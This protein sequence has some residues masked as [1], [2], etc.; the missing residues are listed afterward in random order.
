MKKLF[1]ILLVMVL[2]FST[3]VAPSCKEKDK[4]ETTSL[5][6]EPVSFEKTDVTLVNNKKSDY[7]IVIPDS[8]T[9]METHAA[10]ELQLFIKEST[11]CTL[12]IISD[13]GLTHDNSKKYLSVGETSLLKE[14]TDIEIKF[15]VMGEAGPTVMRRDNTV[16]MC[17]AHAYGTLNSVYKFL[18]Y[19]IGFMAYSIDCVKYDYFTDLKL[20]DFNY[21]YVPTVGKTNSHEDFGED[22]LVALGRM[23]MNTNVPNLGTVELFE[24]M[25]WDGYFCHTNQFIVPQSEYPHLYKNN[26]IC[27]TSEEALQVFCERLFSLLDRNKQIDR[28]NLGVNDFPTSCDC[29][30]CKAQTAKYNGGGVLIR[31]C[32][33]VAKYVENKFIEQGS[34][35]KVELVPLIYYNYITPP[36]KEGA[37]GTLVPI[38]DTVIP[39]SDGQVTIG[40][41]YT[42]ILSCYQHSYANPCDTNIT[43]RDDILGWKV[44][45]DTFYMYSY[46]ANFPG[47]HTYFDNMEYLDEQFKWYH[48]NGIRFT[49]LYE[50]GYGADLGVLDPL[51]MYVRARLGWNPLLNLDELIKDFCENYYGDGGEWVEKYYRATQEH[52][53][54]IYNEKA[55]DCLLPLTSSTANIY[56]PRQTLSAFEGILLNGMSAINNSEY[57]DKDKAL[58]SE[59][60]NRELFLVR[61]NEYIYYNNY[62]E[63]AE[64]TKLL[65]YVNENIVKEGY[66]PTARGPALPIE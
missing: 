22:K 31:F 58:Q 15:E 36:V 43:N 26:Q 40:L 39:K 60:L 48:E 29:D 66:N 46:G 32:N 23:Y 45:T 25:Y 3:L 20:L 49:F 21:Q 24:G 55:T 62:Y 9:K 56:W 59:R 35:R 14:Q 8:A 53:E 7:V 64:R 61:Y 28:M 11:D 1:V 17:G 12:D 41:M 47:K 54:W 2:C 18:E 52:F 37:D 10:E 65:N 51:K 30:T 13:K 33:E 63:Q 50:Q 42:P 27:Y 6:V 4:E 16:Y 44:F 5:Y 19:Q 57:S 34:D 38:D